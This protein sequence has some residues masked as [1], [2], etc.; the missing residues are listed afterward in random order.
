MVDNGYYLRHYEG[1]LASGLLLLLRPRELIRRS[2]DARE[3]QSGVRIY[4][5]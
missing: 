3:L 2:I 1:Q 4:A 5:I